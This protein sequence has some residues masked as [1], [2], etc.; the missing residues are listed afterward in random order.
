[1][2]IYWARKA[3]KYL[4]EAFKTRRA[5][6]RK[7]LRFI[8]DNQEKLQDPI[9]KDKARRGYLRDL[10]DYDI[11]QAVEEIYRNK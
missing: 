7:L 10:S 3:S 2:D 9:F 4:I 5:F 11:S 6:R 1:M 8:S